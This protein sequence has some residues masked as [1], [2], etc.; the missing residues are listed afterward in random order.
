MIRKILVPIDPFETEMAEETIKMAASMSK[1]NNAEVRFVAVV[2]DIPQMVKEVISTYAPDQYQ[3][4]FKKEVRE[5]LERISNDS[6]FDESLCS[7]RV[8]EGNAYH[9]LIA[10][11]E[12]WQADM[13][14]VSSH[15][16]GART[17][18]LGSVAAKIVRHAHCSVTVIRNS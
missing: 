9:E 10:E 15:R 8:R 18:L 3:Y 12:Q 7:V 5:N 17:Y 16:P 6:G 1:S 13:I 14:I 2:Q 4:K 11:A